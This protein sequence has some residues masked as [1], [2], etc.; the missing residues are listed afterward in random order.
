MSYFE[1]F[2]NKE[3]EIEPE[4][5]KIPDKKTIKTKTKKKELIKITSDKFRTAIAL[6]TDSSIRKSIVDCK[7]HIEN[8]L[9]DYEIVEIGRDF[10]F[11]KKNT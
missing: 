3:F 1:D 4:K 5:E 6:I 7:N 2:L 8:F 10:Y 9:Y 11:K